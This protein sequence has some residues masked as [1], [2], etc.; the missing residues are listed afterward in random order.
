MCN[1]SLG[2][3]QVFAEWVWFFAGDKPV[4]W[5]EIDVMLTQR[6]SDDYSWDVPVGPG[7]H[8]YVRRPG[9]GDTVH[10]WTCLY[11]P[12]VSVAVRIFAMG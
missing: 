8:S 6:R 9:P 1:V 7:A 2:S 5:D 11:R 12:W 10:D 4:L 3:R